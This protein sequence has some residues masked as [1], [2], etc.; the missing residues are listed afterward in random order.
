MDKQELIY[1]IKRDI[2]FTSAN[3]A[4]MYK[5]LK[6]NDTASRFF[7]VYYSVFSIIYGLFPLFFEHKI[8]SLP[9]LN[10]L[11][12]SLSIIVLIASLLIS[13]AQYGERSKK[14]MNGLDQLKHLKK[15]LQYDDY[16]SKSEESLNYKKLIKKY[17]K[18]V[19]N[20]ELRSD[21]DYFH[22]CKEFNSR[23][24]YTDDWRQM[25]CFNKVI[26]YAVSI[27]KFTLFL[28]LFLFPILLLFIVF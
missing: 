26:M 24:K 6:I 21:L 27:F 15:C 18:I 20:V 23:G 9:V 10:F 28:A 5:R 19:D 25:S 12:I 13:F 3:Y 7:V 14:I 11:T 22:T 8:V 1:S 17:H 16:S 4:Q 2:E